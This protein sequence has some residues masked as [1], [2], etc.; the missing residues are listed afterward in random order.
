V[1]SD[2]AS[3]PQ[4]GSKDYAEASNVEV[5]REARSGRRL[6]WTVVAGAAIG[7]AIGAMFWYPFGLL[8]VGA[9]GGVAGLVWGTIVQGKET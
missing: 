5:R 1:V 8:V 9:A 7:A 6:I 3:C 2:A 4:C